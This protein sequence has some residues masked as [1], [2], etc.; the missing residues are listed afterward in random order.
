MNLDNIRIVLV[1][2]SHPGNI[3]GTARAMKNMG[4]ERLVLVA[5]RKFPH[6]EADWRAAG[7][8]PTVGNVFATDMKRVMTERSPDFKHGS[9]PAHVK[10]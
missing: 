3:G 7:P 10:E 2:T 6:E 4:F 9:Q 8:I 5:P 1:N